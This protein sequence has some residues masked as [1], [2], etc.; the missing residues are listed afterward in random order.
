MDRDLADITIKFQTLIWD[1]KVTRRELK[2]IFPDLEGEADLNGWEDSD[3]VETTLLEWTPHPPF[4]SK[5]KIKIRV[6]ESRFWD[7]QD[8]N[9]SQSSNRHSFHKEWFVCVFSYLYYHVG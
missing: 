7:F 8:Y 4:L 9:I 2:E 6:C 5:K 3:S 1:E